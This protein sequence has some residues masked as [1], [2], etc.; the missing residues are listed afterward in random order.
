MSGGISARS[1]LTSDSVRLHV[2]EAGGDAPESPVIALVPGWCMPAAIWRGQ[3]LALGRRFRVAALDPRG[4]GDSELP[5]RGFDIDR[6]ADDIHEF[7]SQYRRVVLVGWS[8]A[9]LEALHCVHRHGEAGLA[10]LVL[11]DSS[12]GEDPEPAGGSEFFDDLRR[13]RARAMR[14][15]VRA[16]VRTP[17]PEEI[18]ERLWQGA[19]RMSLEA[20]LSLLPRHL[21]REHWRKLARGFTRPLMYAVS[22]QFAAQAQNLRRHRPATRVELFEHAGHAVFVDEAER[23]GALLADFTA[24]LP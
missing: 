18:R 6:R 20:S 22:G 12:V 1:F 5:R 21:P 8:L 14:D 10:G 7:I 9:A 17:Q 16:M 4:Q 23:F 19:L 3:L 15:F 24:A 2:L 11:V 13:D